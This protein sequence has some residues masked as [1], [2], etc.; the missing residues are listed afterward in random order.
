MSGIRT[1]GGERAML[2]EL[3]AVSMIMA[4]KEMRK[5][6]TKCR[7]GSRFEIKYRL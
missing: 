7:Y 2:G 1:G 4:R 6:R 5:V 3:G